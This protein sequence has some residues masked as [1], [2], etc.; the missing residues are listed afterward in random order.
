MDALRRDALAALPLE[1]LWSLLHAEW[2]V[3]QWRGEPTPAVLKDDVLSATWFTRIA[4]LSPE[5]LAADS[6]RTKLVQS[7]YSFTA[8]LSKGS[9]LDVLSLPQQAALVTPQAEWMRTATTERKQQLAQLY[10]LST[11]G[12]VAA[13]WQLWFEGREAY[14]AQVAGFWMDQ[15]WPPTDATQVWIRRLIVKRMLLPSQVEQWVGDDSVE[16]ALLFKCL[17]EQLQHHFF[18]AWKQHPFELTAALDA[19]PS[20]AAQVVQHGALAVD[21]ETDGQNIWEMGCAQGGGP[22]LL[23]DQKADGAGGIAPALEKLANRIQSAMLLVGHNLLAWD[24]PIL[25]QHNMPQPPVLWDTLLVQYLLEPQARSHALGSNH[26]A[27]ADALAALRLF[28]QQLKRLPDAFARSLCLGEFQDAAQLLQ[29]I[30]QAA[31]TSLACARTQPEWLKLPAI[32]NADAVNHAD[33]VLLLPEHRLRELDWVPGT[34]VVRA[35]PQE[36]LPVDWLQVDVEALELAL[37]L[38]GT[39]HGNAFGQVAAQVL[40]A[41]AQRAA[42]QG[43]GLRRNMIAPWLLEGNDPMEAALVQACRTPAH[44]TQALRVAPLPRD[45]APLLAAGPEAFRLVGLGGDVLV[46]DRQPVASV[47]DDVSGSAPSHRYSPLLRTGPSTGEQ[48]WLQADRAASILS[49]RGGWQSF[50]TVALAKGQVLALPAS[51]TVAQRPA[52]ATRRVPVLYPG[53]LDQASYWIEVMRTFREVATR[54]ADGAVPLLLVGSTRSP[55]LLEMLQIALAEIQW[56]E[57]RPEHRS[58][59]EHLLRAA[60]KKWAVVDTLERW[61][62]WQARAQS[63]G[64]VLLPVVEALPLEQWYAAWHVQSA[65]EPGDEAA[66]TTPADVAPV[67]DL[68]TAKVGDMDR[69]AFADEDEDEDADEGVD[70]DGGENKDKRGDENDEVGASDIQAGASSAAMVSVGTGELLKELPGLLV[71]HLHAWLN[72]TGLGQAERAAVLI[73]ARTAAV[74]GNMAARAE[75]LP[76]HGHPLSVGE[77]D[78]LRRCFESLQI[79]R[80]VAPSDYASMEQFLVKHWQPPPGSGGN[81]VLGFKDSQKSAMQAICSRQSDVLVALP[82]GEGKSV[83]F[84]VPALC[85]GL[86]ARRL[87]LVISPLKALMRDQVEGLRRQGFSESADYLSGDRPAHEIAEITQGV[88]D[89][90]IVLLYV[91]PERLRS[92]LFVEVLRKRVASDG[93]LEYAVVDETH[94]VNQW[95]HEFRPDYF[96]ALH[97]LLREFRSVDGFDHTPFVLLS[98][99][100]TASDRQGLKRIL[101][102]ARTP[103]QPGLPLVVLPEVFAHPLRAHIQV[104]P[105]RVQGM[106]SDS[107]AFDQVFEERLPTITDAIHAAENNHQKTGQ[108]SA[109][110][111]FVAQRTQAEKVAQRLTQVCASQVDYFH[112]GLDVLTRETVYERFR[113]GDLTV[114]VA[115]KAFGMGMDIPD[116]H[117][118]IHLSPPAFLEDYLQEVGRIGRGAAQREKAQLEHLNACLLFSGADFEGIRIQ[119]AQ[120]ALQLAFIKN[121]YE[122]IAAKA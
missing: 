4:S 107:Q 101:Q 6:A 117:W 43:I 10:L 115:T 97:L 108:R 105:S 121:Q 28:E 17:P 16:A 72:E 71:R 74:G 13:D 87:T 98:A 66:D 7:R 34:T 93:G 65:Q 104:L 62:Q 69:N 59:R 11:G 67:D 64:V 95:G 38:Q 3:S 39:H 8:E 82:T 112:A 114:L 1:E 54:R 58:Q 46:F 63:A 111:I 76:L 30:A 21:L 106:M 81:S 109:V 92:E 18:I 9:R 15:D 122:Q 73:D 120:G 49:K 42:A 70:A 32:S 113:E 20:L 19:N 55:Q 94:C 84:Q 37:A 29:A 83:L 90:R 41:V 48:L 77:A 60:H 47:P 36:N 110:I 61:P 80:E 52:L 5:A 51:E 103:D 102:A 25:S 53:A 99:T 86:R 75:L 118:A 40:L 78:C 50:R 96:H 22:S 85:R 24:W 88:L 56:G 14:E 91:A 57:V 23:Y 89:H 119:R 79:E 26:H 45:M 68:E 27:D 12:R 116:I 35:H 2:Y 31:G 44:S 100:V 33:A